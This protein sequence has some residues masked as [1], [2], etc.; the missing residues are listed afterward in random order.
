MSTFSRIIT[1]RY[2]HQETTICRRL[3]ELES[4]SI[5][6]F[7][8]SCIIQPYD[9]TWSIDA[10]SKISGDIQALLDKLQRAFS[11]TPETTTQ[12]SAT[13]HASIAVSLYQPKLSFVIVFWNRPVEHCMPAFKLT[14]QDFGAVTHGRA[15]AA[16]NVSPI[17]TFPL[18]R[19]RGLHK[20]QPWGL[21][22]CVLAVE[23][24]LWS[25]WPGNVY[26]HKPR[27]LTKDIYKKLARFCAPMV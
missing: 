11:S 18:C 5:T 9:F 21:P 19:P 12:T 4:V 1:L 17:C 10:I 14:K 13:S 20:K 7:I 26:F 8:R 6:C 15:Y 27:V 24:T 16:I 2:C 22:T 3:I 23:R 25:L